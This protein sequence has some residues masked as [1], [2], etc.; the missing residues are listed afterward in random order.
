MFTVA[1]SVSMMMFSRTLHSMSQYVR[2]VP[3]MTSDNK[4]VVNYRIDA[5]PSSIELL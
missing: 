2:N 5:F 4:D 1:Q 3:T